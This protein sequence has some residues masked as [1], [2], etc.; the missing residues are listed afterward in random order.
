M[1]QYDDD[2]WP[3]THPL[4]LWIY[5]K[6]ILSSRL[7]YKCGPVG[8]PVPQS[9]LY[10][11]RPITNVLGMGIGAEEVYITNQTD[12]L[13]PGYFWCEKFTGRHLSIDYIDKKIVNCVEGLRD[14]GV[15]LWKWRSWKKVSISIPFPR[16]LSSLQNTTEVNCEYIDGK[17][18]EVH[19]RLNYDMGGYNEVIPMWDGEPFD[20]SSQGYTYYTNPD[21]RRLGFWKK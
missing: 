8:V 7:G 12:H 15:P 9:G 4:D 16:V 3:H 17:L 13:R 19:Q 14:H 21:Q 2:L 10:I 5:D 1:I 20:L 11:V 18:I 6:L